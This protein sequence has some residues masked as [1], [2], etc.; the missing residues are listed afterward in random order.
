MSGSNRTFFLRNSKKKSLFLTNNPWQCDLIFLYLGRS[1]ERP[2]KQN[3]NHWGG[4]SI[5]VRAPACHA[6]VCEF[7]PRL[8]REKVLSKE[9]TFRLCIVTPDLFRGYLTRHP[10]RHPEHR[11]GSSAVSLT[12]FPTLVLQSLRTHYQ[13]LKSRPQHSDRGDTRRNILYTQHRKVL[14]YAN[15]P[16]RKFFHFFSKKHAFSVDKILNICIFGT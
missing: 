3:K 12:L 13:S 6:G 16:F 2:N 4:S 11:E 14:F 10:Q 15:I 8:S 5:L 9:R 1:V 7:K